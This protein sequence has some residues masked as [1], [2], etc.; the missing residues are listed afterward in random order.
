ME[1]EKEKEKEKEM[2]M[3]KAKEKVKEMERGTEK[4]KEEAKE[5]EREKERE[6][7]KHWPCVGE[8]DGYDFD[9][10]LCHKKDYFSQ[11]PYKDSILLFVNSK[12]HE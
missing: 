7:E 12:Y 10:F 9:L 1:K 6:R 2:E 8:D 4:G 11:K 3:E 5:M